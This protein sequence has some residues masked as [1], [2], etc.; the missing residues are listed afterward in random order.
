MNKVFKISILLM[1]MVIMLTTNVFA[2]VGT[3]EN[4]STEEY[5]AL[6]PHEIKSDT[7]TERSVKRGDFFSRADVVISNQGN[8]DIGALAVA[9]MNHNVDEIYITVYLDRWDEETEKWRQVDYYD[10]EYYADDYPDGLSE[11]T[12]N[13]T[14]LNQERECYYRLRGVFSAVY[15]ND[16]E[17]FSPTTSGIWID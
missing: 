17:G 4:S 2:S 16:Y 5:S 8:G 12:L 13:I 14:F 1:A 7:A 11:A 15:D 3:D 6:L 9:Y 10:A